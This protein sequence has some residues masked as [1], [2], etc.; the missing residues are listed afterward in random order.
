[1]T[2]NLSHRVQESYML[3]NATC[4]LVGK[5]HESRQAGT[6]NSCRHHNR[7]RRVMLPLFAVTITCRSRLGNRRH[8]TGDHERVE[9]FI[10]DTTDVVCEAHVALN[11][12][13]CDDG[14][15]P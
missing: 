13:L 8:Q 3:L 4:T 12:Y 6:D 1:M 2:Y 15:S 11:Y 9:F 14:V 7:L 5:G 10:T